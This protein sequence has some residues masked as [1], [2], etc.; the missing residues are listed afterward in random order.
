MKP[1]AP[2]GTECNNCGLCCSRSLCPLATA[3]FNRPALPGPCP[4]LEWEGEDSRC[5]L[6]ANPLRYA[7]PNAPGRAHPD[8]LVQGAAFV[9]GAG[10]GCDAPAE[11]EVAPPAYRRKLRQRDHSKQQALALR[12]LWLWIGGTGR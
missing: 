7:H 8:H 5:G 3:V 9:I 4:A 12:K 6:M 10:T 1:K 11:G 2:Y